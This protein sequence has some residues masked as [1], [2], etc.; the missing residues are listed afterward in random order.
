MEEA[1]RSFDSRAAIGGNYLTNHRKVSTPNKQ[2]GL[3]GPSGISQVEILRTIV[4]KY[5]ERISHI[6][7]LHN[8]IIQPIKYCKSH[9]DSGRVSYDYKCL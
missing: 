8:H 2:W 3:R 9:T 7:S 6:I 1:K 4:Q 5:K